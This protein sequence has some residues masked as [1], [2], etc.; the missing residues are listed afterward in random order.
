MSG[1]GCGRAS[2]PGEEGGVGS[3]ARHRPRRERVSDDELLD[4]VITRD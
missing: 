2:A 1:R 3:R 4:Y